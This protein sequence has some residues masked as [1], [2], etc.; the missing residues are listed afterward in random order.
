MVALWCVVDAAPGH[1]HNG[2]LLPNKALQLTALR[3]AL[4][5]SHQRSD[6][7][8]GFRFHRWYRVA[9][10]VERDGEVGV[11]GPFADHCGRAKK[12]FVRRTTVQGTYIPHYK[13]ESRRPNCG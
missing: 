5:S 6:L 4:A 13:S 11:S 7:F 9:V 10:R 3:V 12:P 8:S 1:V 2:C